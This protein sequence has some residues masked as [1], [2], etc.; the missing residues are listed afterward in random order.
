MVC[1]TGSEISDN[2][3]IELSKKLGKPFQDILIRDIY[4]DME[5]DK[6][7]LVDSIVLSY[8]KFCKCTD[9][10]KN[11]IMYLVDSTI[12]EMVKG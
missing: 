2:S 7:D 12:K 5:S 10:E 3:D 11:V 9:M 8:Y 1:F 4:D 6:R